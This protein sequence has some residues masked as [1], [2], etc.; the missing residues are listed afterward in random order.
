M[1][2]R[3][4]TDRPTS[5]EI[6]EILDRPPVLIEETM[7]CGTRLTQRWQHGA[8]HNSLPALADHVIMT[9]Y[10]QDREI[11]FQGDE[12]RFASRTRPGSITIIPAGSAGRWDVAGSIEVSHVYLPAERL[13]AAAEI[14]NT[15]Q[16]IELLG[17]VGFADPVAAGILELLSREAGADDPSAR[18][19]VEQAIDLLNT[20]LI[21][22]HS[23]VRALPTPEVKRGL[24]PWQIKRVTEYM[25]EHLGDEISLNELAGVVHLSRF[26]FVTAFRLATGKT[27]HEWLV[28]QRIG[29][30]KQLLG[31]LFLNITEIGLSVGYGTPSAFTAAFRKVVGVPPT[32]FR[33][34]L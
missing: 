31:D 2:Q 23:S 34:A 15:G 20:Q 24:A 32:E 19:F 11:R 27:P 29:R 7:R 12:G 17:R 9:Y 28:L 30:A 5:E 4:P 1:E 8:V 21:R 6:G 16:R 3:R 13:R 10:G 25:N 22:G 18:L 14:L 33:R 26:H